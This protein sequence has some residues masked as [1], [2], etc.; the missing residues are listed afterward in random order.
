MS[1]WW[2]P[3]T[4]A[5]LVIKQHTKLYTFVSR[6]LSELYNIGMHL[7]FSDHFLC[8]S[9]CL[10]TWV[11]SY[12]DDK[13]NEG[14]VLSPA[15]KHAV[16]GTKRKCSCSHFYVIFRGGSIEEGC[17]QLELSSVLQ[18]GKLSIKHEVLFHFQSR[19]KPK[20]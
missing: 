5:I 10:D 4:Y 12:S 16:W 7:W 3:S 6:I 20:S 1:S 8:F 17:L 14:A 9:F 13:W 18:G 2:L 19:K 11:F 15:I